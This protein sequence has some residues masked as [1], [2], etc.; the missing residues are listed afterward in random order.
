VASHLLGLTRIERVAIEAI[1]EERPEVVAALSERL[2][3]VLDALRRS[4]QGRIVAERQADNLLTELG[5]AFVARMLAE[6]PPWEEDEDLREPV[7]GIVTRHLLAEA[8]ERV[9]EASG[10][11][12]TE[13]TGAA[14]RPRF[15]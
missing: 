15:R 9:V 10:C 8:R 7:V 2:A 6:L 14:R 3:R 5:Q 4:S 13:L 12:V 1:C 11:C